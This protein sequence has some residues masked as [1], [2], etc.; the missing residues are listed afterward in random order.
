VFGLRQECS[1]VRFTSGMFRCSVY[2]RNV[3]VFGLRQECSGVRF[4]SGMFRC[5]VYVRNVQVFFLVTIHKTADSL[6]DY[7]S[8]S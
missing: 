1:G 7:I 5:S 3:Q 4:T 8:V 2:V 6:Q